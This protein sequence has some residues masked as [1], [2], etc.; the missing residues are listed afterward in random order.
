MQ[1]QDLRFA[2][3]T[4]ANSGLCYDGVRTIFE[5]SRGHVWI[6]TYMGL[7]RFDGQTFLCFSKQELGIDSDFVSSVSEDQNGTVFVGTDAGLC[8][9]DA[10]TSHFRS[11]CPEILHTRVYSMQKDARGDF[12]IGSR[13]TGLYRK[14]GDRLL[15]APGTEH[16]ENVYRMAPDSKGRLYLASYCNDI[17]LYDGTSLQPLCDGFFKDDDVE[18]LVLDRFTDEEVLYVASKRSGLCRV[19]PQT[20]AVEV[21][22]AIQEGHRPVGIASD[23]YAIWL[24][25]TGGLVKYDIQSGTSML[26][27][28]QSGNPFALSAD[29]V[30]AVC[31]DHSGGLWV[32]TSS[33]G[34]N[35]SHPDQG[36]FHT[37]WHLSSAL[38]K[39][40][41]RMTT[42]TCG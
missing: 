30:T 31:P 9:F 17:Y 11:F 1:A 20:G 12:W 3:F 18:G 32:G 8:L 33:T 14:S 25:T 23:G 42:G 22:Y 24:S 40:L 6:G 13:G 27:C 29:Y 35:Y 10:H 2:H 39:V 19:N 28:S 4:R 41:P 7:S 26:Y 37:W 5:D 16:L 15:L 38:S 34:V 36:R 21:L